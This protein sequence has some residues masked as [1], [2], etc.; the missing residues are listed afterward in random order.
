MKKTAP[1]KGKWTKTAESPIEKQIK[2]VKELVKDVVQTFDIK[3]TFP[4]KKIENVDILRQLV[5]EL[6]KWVLIYTVKNNLV[7]LQR[8]DL[9]SEARAMEHKSIDHI[10]T[11][12]TSLKSYPEKAETT[13]PNPEDTIK[14][15]EI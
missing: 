5:K 4:E 6:E 12:A 14:T 15:M 11:L 7:K 2:D 9:A 8:F 10:Q 13:T 3:V 1:Q